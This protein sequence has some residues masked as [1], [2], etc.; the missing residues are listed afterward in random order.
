MSSPNSNFPGPFL[1]KLPLIQ[2]GMVPLMVVEI[3]WGVSSA[4]LTRGAMLTR[5]LASGHRWVL[6]AVRGREGDP[7]NKCHQIKLHFKLNRQ[8]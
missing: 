7:L 3:G 6:Q 1:R 8:K 2:D 4:E 5:P